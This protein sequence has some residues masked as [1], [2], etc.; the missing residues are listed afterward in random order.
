MSSGGVVQS[1]VVSGGGLEIA[2]AG[3]V[4]SGTVVS[5]GGT[6]IVKA[7]ATGSGLIVSSGASD[8]VGGTDNGATVLG[9]QQVGAGGLVS[10][11]S[12][13]SGGGET[14]LSGGTASTV[15]IGA[16]SWQYVESGG[17]VSGVT[18]GGYQQVDSGGLVNG[19]TISS[20]ACETVQVGGS[21]ITV[22]IAHGGYQYLKSGAVVSGV[23]VGGYQEVD[24]GRNGVRR[25]HLDRGP[26]RRC[27]SAGPP[28]ASPRI[29]A[30]STIVES[31]AHVVSGATL[32][33]YQ[34]VDS[35]G[36]AVNCHHLVGGL[37]DGGSRTARR[38]CDS[39]RRRL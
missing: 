14:V 17:L 32:G 26:A 25:H 30:A 36:T 10:G 5:A 19:A 18:I 27:R 2:S 31:G 4:V 6:V 38:Q 7:G 23:T 3:G 16:G 9:F 12:F 29:T 15:T 33:G 13:L 21:A 20:G 22:M 39:R 1:A 34:Q 24:S 35:G 28:A 11:T 8:Y 37:R